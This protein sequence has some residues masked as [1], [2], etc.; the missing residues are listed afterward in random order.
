MKL[1]RFLY[2]LLFLAVYIFAS[3]IGG[4]ISYLLLYLVLFIPILSII[5]LVYVCFR[6]R[7]YQH[8]ERKVLIKGDHISYNF[9]LSNE[10]FI[11]YTD[12]R[13]IFEEKTSSVEKISPDT[14]YCLLPGEDIKK[15]TTL[16]CHY[17][18]QYYVGINHVI[19]RD[20]FHLFKIKYTYK[21]TVE[22]QVMP[23]VLQLDKLEIGPNEDNMKIDFRNG[24]KKQMVKDN[25]VRKYQSG[26][27]M[28]L[29]HWKSSA[30]TR[31]LMSQK[32]ADEPKTEVISVIDLSERK[33]DKYE[34]I[35]TED[36]MLEAVLAIHNY[37]HLNSISSKVIY[38]NKAIEIQSIQDKS[39]FDNFYT[40]CKS[41]LFQ[42][43]YSCSE[44][45]SYAMKI[46]SDIGH[47]I[48]LTANLNNELCITC[49]QAVGYGLEL[50]I[51]YVGDEDLMLRKSLLNNKIHLHVINLDVEVEEILSNGREKS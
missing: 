39:D 11:A 20:F 15:Q 18:G 48:I 25:E 9:H 21:S 29:I 45:V 33:I 17:R 10:G 22:V 26:D 50:T 14:S 41:I 16:C 2:V 23:R 34:K 51:I 4:T 37:F 3:N 13:V 43:E 30:K 32:Y 40:I 19:V 42:S 38:G 49:N 46:G 6:F 35:V 24:S 44:L 8:V 5:Y 27:T 31:T 12:V 1:N 7:I 36:K 47:L 28:K